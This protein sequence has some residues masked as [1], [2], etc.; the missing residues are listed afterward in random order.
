MK[1]RDRY[2]LI[3]AATFVGVGL[4]GVLLNGVLHPKQ[5]PMN[6]PALIAAS[7]TYR[8]DLEAK[9]LPVPESVSLQELTNHGYLR[10]ADVPGLAGLDVTIALKPEET[11]PHAVQ[12]RVRFPDGDERILLADGSVHRT[13][14][15]SGPTP[16][17]P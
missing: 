11:Q 7:H 12:A 8:R 17:H 2:L 10:A 4:L 13:L 16:A 5:P 14:P 6:F 1:D 9:N 15:Q 3:I